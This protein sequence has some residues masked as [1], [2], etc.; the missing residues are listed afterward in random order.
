MRQGEPEEER[1]RCKAIRGVPESKGAARVHGHEYDEREEH[2][3]VCDVKRRLP[4]PEEELQA[5]H[6]DR[7]PAV[8]EVMLHAGGAYVGERGEVCARFP[9]HRIVV[10]VAVDGHQVVQRQHE[11]KDRARDQSRT[12]RICVH[13]FPSLCRLA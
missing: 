6:R 12:K 4:E 13:Y 10:V 5:E 9:H 7:A 11:Q 8:E 3:R 2:Q 1:R